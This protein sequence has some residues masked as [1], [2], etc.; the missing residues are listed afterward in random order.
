MSCTLVRL[1]KVRVRQRMEID[2]A[3]KAFD[4]EV[5]CVTTPVS[6]AGKAEKVESNLL[7]KICHRK[8]T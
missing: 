4:E 7:L 8:S 6:N 2:N 1:L 5:A 3:R